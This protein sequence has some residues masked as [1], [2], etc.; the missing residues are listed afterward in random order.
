MRS[1]KILNTKTIAKIKSVPKTQKC[2]YNIAKAAMPVHGMAA[3]RKNHFFTFVRHTSST[4]ATPLCLTGTHSAFLK[5]A[6]MHT[7]M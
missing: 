3:F 5:I 7:G 2:K 1:I 4:E 6:A